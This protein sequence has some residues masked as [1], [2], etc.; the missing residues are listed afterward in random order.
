[1][2]SIVGYGD[3]FQFLLK[4][5]MSKWMVDEVYTRGID[6]SLRTNPLL[7]PMVHRFHLLRMRISHVINSL[8]TFVM[9]RVVHSLGLE[10]QEKLD[11]AT[12]L[13]QV[14][15]LHDWYVG[16][17]KDRCLLRDR[18][19]AVNTAILEIFN[20]AYDCRRC[21][22]TICLGAEAVALEAAVVDAELEF[23]LLERRFKK[24]VR[25]LVTLLEGAVKKDI[26]P[27]LAGLYE[28]I[29]GAD[30]FDPI[31]PSI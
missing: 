18:A 9:T 25:F 24:A 3:I 7:I 26:Y 28:S 6:P 27:H 4:I 22:D 10:F 20:A 31:F 2:A 8:S 11:A 1:M 19:A 14:R 23:R 5:K 16:E 30:T 12:D 15:Q 29:K 17:L 13:D 21:W